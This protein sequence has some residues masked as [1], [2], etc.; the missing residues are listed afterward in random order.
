MQGM[1]ACPSGGSSSSRGAGEHLPMRGS[2]RSGSAAATADG[3]AYITQPFALANHLG[4]VVKIGEGRSRAALH[5]VHTC[6]HAPLLDRQAAAWRTAPAQRLVLHYH[7]SCAS[8]KPAWL[9][10]GCSGS[11][12]FA[13][14]DMRSDGHFLYIYP[15]YHQ[16]CCRLMGVWFCLVFCPSCVSTLHLRV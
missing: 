9:Q 15:L 11:P 3:C 4:R 5:S 14:A 13:C 2:I 16:A 7:S 12:T 6:A 8:M 1:R 10:M